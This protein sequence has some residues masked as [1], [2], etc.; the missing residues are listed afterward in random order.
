MTKQQRDTR[1]RTS[2]EASTTTIGAPRWLAILLVVGGVAGLVAAFALTVEKLEKLEH[3]DAVLGCDFNPFLNCSGAMDSW[4]G[5]VFGPP[6]SLWGMMAFVAPIA[7]GVAVLA[8]ARFARWFWTTF[9]IGI[10]LG[11]AFALWLAYSSIFVLGLICPWCF[12]VWCA[13][14][15]MTF[16]LLTWGLG[17]GALPASTG[18]RAWAARWTEWSWVASLA[19]LV[20]VLLAFVITRPDAVRFILGV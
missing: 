18:V 14:Y 20:I 13:M 15:A 9:A 10:V 1:A 17:S 6:N 16:P 4:Q 8:G 5:A 12:L 7:V 2:A 19:L 3:P 11:L